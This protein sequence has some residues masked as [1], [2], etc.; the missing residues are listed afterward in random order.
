MKQRHR[1]IELIP[2][3]MRSRQYSWDDDTIPSVFCILLYCIVICISYILIL[4]YSHYMTIGFRIQSVC[5]KS[6]ITMARYT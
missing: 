4:W 5:Y 6:M 1:Y 3:S 2:N